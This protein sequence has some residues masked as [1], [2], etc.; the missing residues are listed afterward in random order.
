MSLKSFLQDKDTPVR[1][2]GVFGLIAILFVGAALLNRHPEPKASAVNATVA[3]VVNT[4]AAAGK[5][6]ANRGAQLKDD[7]DHVKNTSAA[8]DDMGDTGRA[9]VAALCRM[10]AYTESP[11]EAC[12]LS[13]DGAGRVEGPATAN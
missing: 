2:A 7:I 12:K 6:E 1:V 9:G 11:P 10:R 13:I 4:V 5:R 3:P 8:S